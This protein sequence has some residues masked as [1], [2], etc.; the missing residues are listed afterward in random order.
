MNASTITIR[1]AEP[2][3]ALAL[4]TL[5]GSEGVV[6]GTLQMPMVAHATRVD[7]LSKS[8]PLGIRLVAV[9]PDGTIA[10]YAGLGSVGNSLRRAHA[11]YLFITIG[12]D[13]QGQGIGDR[14]M[15]EVLH[16]ADHWGAV[17]RIELTV[18]A[19]NA[20][21]IALYEKHGFVHEGRL[22]AMALRDGEYVDGLG[23]AR[24]HPKP[25]QL[26]TAA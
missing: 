5:I 3:D 16:W 14:L 12:K 10:G 17:L 9:T 13:W 7:N 8:D 20:R 23:M 26:P 6:E 19:D 2:A 24:L 4:S 22:R 1:A 18:F 21:A 25:P 15:R 11:R